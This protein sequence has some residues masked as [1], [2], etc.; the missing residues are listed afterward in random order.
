MRMA[1]QSILEKR[2]VRQLATDS[3]FLFGST[4]LLTIALLAIF[5][6][7]VLHQDPT[8]GDLASRFAPPMWMEGGD[9]AYPL[10][11]DQLGRDVLTR[12]VYGA[13]VSLMVGLMAV[14]IAGLIG[15]GVGVFAGYRGGWVDATV[16]R[17]A[18]IQLAFPFLVLAI[19][20]AAVLGPGLRNTVVI[21]GV[22]GWVTYARVTRSETL[23][24]R[25]QEFVQAAI[26]IGTPSRR[27][28]FRH[29]FP[30]TIPSIIVVATFA[31]S[32]MIIA[33]ATLSFLGFGI[34]PP[35]PSWGGML[36]DSRA[37]LSTAPWVALAP[38]IALALV[39]LSVNL[40]GDA[41]RDALSPRR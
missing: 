27:I 33:E 1:M 13:R 39:V 22:A 35:T 21:L 9:A 41:V 10:G 2:W 19:T 5:A 23:T 15:V 36:S 32:D 31:F 26:A 7:L 37:Y 6:P 14:L 24:I 29:V 4:L 40:V 8:Q 18:D 28:V 11:A 30:N 3:G 25:E 17:V 16:A 12:T 38:A 34:V 20:A